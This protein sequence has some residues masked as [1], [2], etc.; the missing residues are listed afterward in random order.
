MLLFRRPA[1][2]LAVGEHPLLH[3]QSVWVTQRKGVSPSQDGQVR[4]CHSL[5][6]SDWFKKRHLSWAIECE[7]RDFC[8]VTWEVMLSLCGV[9]E[10]GAVETGSCWQTSNPRGERLPEDAATGKHCF[11]RGNQADRTV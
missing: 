11:R 7:L 9:C 2:H 3:S 4:E 1:S 5:S 10:A 6:S 8:E